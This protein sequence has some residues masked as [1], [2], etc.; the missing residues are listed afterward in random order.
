MHGP[1]SPFLS[2]A[3]QARPGRQSACWQDERERR[4]ERRCGAV[5]SETNAPPTPTNPLQTPPTEPAPPPPPDIPP[6]ELEC[7]SDA[8]TALLLLRAHWAADTFGLVK[9][10]RRDDDNDNAAAA[11]DI[12]PL[13]PTCP[14]LLHSQVHALV[15]DRGAADVELDELR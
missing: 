10:K 13:P 4:R 2:D 14:I 12:T 11:D 15:T 6:A 7:P 8:M 3:A 5:N 9:V 1:L